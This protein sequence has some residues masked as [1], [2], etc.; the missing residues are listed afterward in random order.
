MQRRS[1]LSLLALCI[2]LPVPLAR[3]DEAAEQLVLATYKLANE[4]STA[5]GM[6]VRYES[7]DGQTRSFVV[8]AHH[9][10]AQT[11]GD[12]CALVSRSRRED[13]TFQRREIQVAV[14]DAGKPLWI[15]H[16]V[17][18]LAVLP[19]PSD[20]DVEALPFDSLATEE[21]LVEVRVGDAV[22]LA[23]FPERAEANNAGFAILR[24]GSIASY[25]VIP[26]KHHP[27][28]LGDG[29]GHRAGNAQRHRRRQRI[30]IRRT[31][32]ALSA[33]NLRSSSRRHDPQFDRR[34]RDLGLED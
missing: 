12:S 8:T 7:E 33:G 30:A 16:S 25:P 21:Q 26:V 28:F 4:V 34:T 32:D 11:K 22:R 31:Q 10:L 2:L 24:S 18:D 5:S 20:L 1:H 17:H 6:V 29:G 13:G 23:V 14:R 9:V 19:L 15:K 3:S 27:M